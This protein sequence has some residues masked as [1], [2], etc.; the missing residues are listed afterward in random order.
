MLT[1][2]ELNDI[3]ERNPNLKI[4]EILEYLREKYHLE[5]SD[6]AVFVKSNKTLFG[7]LSKECNMLGLI[8]GDKQV[9][10]EKIF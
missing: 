5:A 1:I 3:R 2:G 9:N 10:L 4:L 6:V 8:K 7:E